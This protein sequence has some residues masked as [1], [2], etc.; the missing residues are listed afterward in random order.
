M[1]LLCITLCLLIVQQTHKHHNWQPFDIGLLLLSSITLTYFIALVNH[2]FTIEVLIIVLLA[3]NFSMR[4]KIA[5][6]IVSINFLTYHFILFVVINFIIYVASLQIDNIYNLYLIGFSLLCYLD[7]VYQFTKRLY[8]PMETWM[9]LITAFF[10]LTTTLIIYELRDPQVFSSTSFTLVAILILTMFIIIFLQIVILTNYYEK[11]D[12]LDKLKKEFSPEYNRL[13]KEHHDALEHISHRAIDQTL[14]NKLDRYF[15]ENQLPLYSDE[16]EWN[17][18]MYYAFK[19]HKN[20]SFI[21]KDAIGGHNIDLLLFYTVHLLRHFDEDLTVTSSPLE[22]NTLLIE[23][24]RDKVNSKQLS[25]FLNKFKMKT[26]KLEHKWH[27]DA[28]KYLYGLNKV[29]YTLQIE[30]SHIIKLRIGGQR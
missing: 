5:S 9:E 14:K 12:D 27:L 6:M 20:T 19:T 16:L 17:F 10:A 2:L 8:K 4:N 18:V 22:D 13:L 11:K 24:S 15:I 26:I 23:L 29:S 1:I 28:I 7:H 25:L 30:T 21:S 3:L